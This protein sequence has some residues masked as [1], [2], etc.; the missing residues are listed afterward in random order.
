MVETGEIGK[1][2]LFEINELLTDLKQAPITAK[3]KSAVPKLIPTPIRKT[4]S[5]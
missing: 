2:E 5:G 3:P 1:D 4:K